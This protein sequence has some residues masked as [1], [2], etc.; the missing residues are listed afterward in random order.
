MTYYIGGEVNSAEILGTGN[1]KF[2]YALRRTTEGELYF[3]KINQIKDTDSITVNVPG[4]TDDNFSGFDYGVD[5]FDGRTDEHARPHPN[6]YWDQYRWDNQNC[7]Y[8]IN[9]QG[10]L[11]VRINQKYTYSGDEI[12]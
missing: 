12:I 7:Y 6:L 11:V 2:L 5:F 1:S 10:E 8:Y 9:A 4:K 3:A